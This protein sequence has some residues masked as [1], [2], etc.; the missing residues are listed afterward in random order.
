MQTNTQNYTNLVAT[1]SKR[2]SLKSSIV[3]QKRY[4]PELQHITRD[5]TSH[6]R[7]QTSWAGSPGTGET[8][9]P[10]LN[11]SVNHTR[12]WLSPGSQFRCGLRIRIWC[13]PVSDHI[14]AGGSCIWGI[15]SVGTWYWIS[16]PHFPIFS[17]M[18]VPDAGISN[19]NHAPT[20]MLWGE[21][22]TGAHYM[23]YGHI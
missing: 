6:K 4:C 20:Y 17:D 18:L 3:P 15:E 19:P 13:R 5:I 14:G 21:I 12:W 10:V 11:L 23:C 2:I 8:V 16:L 7:V 9:T 1:K 22:M